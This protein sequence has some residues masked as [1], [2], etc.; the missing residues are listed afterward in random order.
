MG[1]TAPPVQPVQAGF[2]SFPPFIHGRMGG[3]E[4]EIPEDE[5]SGFRRYFTLERK[6]GDIDDQDIIEILTIFASCHL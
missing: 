1:A 2:V 4:A 6:E 3:L 5:G